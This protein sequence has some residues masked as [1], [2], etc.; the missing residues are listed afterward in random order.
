VDS[1][2][3]EGVSS[4]LALSETPPVDELE[5]QTWASYWA[6]RRLQHKSARNYPEADRIRA[7]LAQHGFEVRDSKDGSIQVVRTSV[8]RP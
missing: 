5:A 1:R 2:E 6:T 4:S 8:R 7:L 3:K